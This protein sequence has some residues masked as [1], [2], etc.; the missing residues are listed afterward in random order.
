[1]QAFDPTSFIIMVFGASAF[2]LIMFLLVL[3]ELKKPRDAGSKKIMNRLVA[4]QVYAKIV[5][6][7]VD[8]EAFDQA[9]V[10]RVS[11]IIAALPNLEL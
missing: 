4:C 2:I 9:I 5:S 6:L 1:M 3:L 8:E 7:E 11:E 10:T